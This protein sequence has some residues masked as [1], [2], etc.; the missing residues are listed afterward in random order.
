MRDLAT[1][2]VIKKAVCTEG[3]GEFPDSIEILPCSF[4]KV[5]VK[6]ERS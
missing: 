4:G 1:A 3:T 5:V 6:P 2:K